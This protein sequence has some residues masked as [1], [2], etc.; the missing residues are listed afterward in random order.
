MS[1]KEL[2]RHVADALGWEPS[3]DAADVGVSVD[4]GVVTLR[5]DV[6]TVRGEIGCRT[7][8]ASRVWCQGCRQRHQRSVGRR[9][10]AYR[11]GHRTGCRELG[12]VERGGAGESSVRC[13]QQR[14]DY[15]LGDGALELSKDGGRA[16]GSIWPACEASGTTSSSSRK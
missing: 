8:H 12:P 4:N 16:S 5:G 7:R 13:G 15:A 2:Q 9:V 11:L 10:P 14:L 1:D 6:P 3:V